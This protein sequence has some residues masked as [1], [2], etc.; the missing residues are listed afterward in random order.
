MDQI[1]EKKKA[2]IHSRKTKKL[3]NLDRDYQNNQK[4]N[5]FRVFCHFLYFCVLL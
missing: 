5:F 2:K 1:D 4:K 3:S